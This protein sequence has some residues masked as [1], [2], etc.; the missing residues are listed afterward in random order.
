MP[1]NRQYNRKTKYPDK[2][3]KPKCLVFVRIF[4]F[5]SVGI[6][7]T[8]FPTAPLIGNLNLKNNRHKYNLL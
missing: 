8:Y 3:T 7:I 2:V 6:K 4:L 5:S 1:K